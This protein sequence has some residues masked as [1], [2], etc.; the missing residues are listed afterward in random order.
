[1][2]GELDYDSNVLCCTVRYCT[3]LYGTAL[4]CT[5]HCTV[6]PGAGING[7]CTAYQL[8]KRGTKVLLLEKVYI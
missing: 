5:I 8:A 7:S 6:L 4:Y 2:Q 1:M 3:V